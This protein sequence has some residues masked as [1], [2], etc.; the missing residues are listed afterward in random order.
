MSIVGWILLLAGAAISVLIIIG[1]AP[2]VLLNL[3]VPLL[4][5]MGIAVLGLVIVLL[6]RRPGD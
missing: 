1:Q 5:W 3:P 4:A 2:E 6:T